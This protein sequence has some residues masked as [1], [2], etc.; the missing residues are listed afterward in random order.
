[1]KIVRINDTVTVAPEAISA[2]RVTQATFY[3]NS[4]GWSLSILPIMSS[5]WVELVFCDSDASKE[6]V[7]A[8]KALIE[9]AME[10]DK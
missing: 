9:E 1:M 6:S 7:M 4:P 2:V 3:M 5:E 10:N 8:L